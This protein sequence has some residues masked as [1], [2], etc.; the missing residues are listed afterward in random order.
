[1]GREA[2]W[3]TVQRVPKRW[4]KLKQLSAAQHNT[5]VSM[6]SDICLVKGQELASKQL[7]TGQKNTTK[8]K[9]R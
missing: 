5:S 3:A 6:L 2:W 4:A 8:A 9:L 1:M 7:K